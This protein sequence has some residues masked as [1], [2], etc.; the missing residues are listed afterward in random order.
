MTDDIYYSSATQIAERVRSKDISPVEVMESHLERTA[1]LNPALNAVV[2]L[3]DSAMDRARQAEDAVARGEVWGPL[4]GVPF[5]A[6]DSFDV[7]GLRTTRG[8]NFFKDFKPVTDAAA[9]ARL[10]QAGAIFIGHTNVPE[11]VFWFETDN[12]VFGRTQNPWMLSRTSG[13]SSGGEASAIAAGLSP[14]GVGSDLACS[15]RQ[16]ASICG[17]YGLKPTH[18]RVP[19][20]GHWPDAL[21]PYMHAGPMARNVEDIALALSVMSGP[22]GIDP[23]AVPVPVTRPEDVHGDV[24]GLRVAW[25]AEGPFA[26]VT[27]EVQGVVEDAAR[28][29]EAQGCAVDEVSLTELEELPGQDISIVLYTGELYPFLEPMI[30]GREGELSPPITRRMKVPEPSAREYQKALADCERLRREFAK[31]FT[32]YDLLLS[33]TTVAP[34]H[35]HDAAELDVDGTMVPPRN[36]VRATVPFDLTGS[37]ALSVPFGWSSDGLPIGVHLAGRH[38][39][40]TTILNAGLALDKVRPGRDRRPELKEGD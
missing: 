8:S 7:G 28:A 2:T 30:S 29:L 4:H 39:E 5:T 24:A 15:I 16:P 3:D 18:G 20:T 38:F 25:C 12:S 10:K 23:H 36:A 6:K 19:L 11:F 1:S 14:L 35:P 32:A 22:D 40:E 17:I 13:G 9:I 33:P 34:A 37:P 26:P 27:K 31:L 21:L